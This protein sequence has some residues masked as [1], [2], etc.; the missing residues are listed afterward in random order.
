MQRMPAAVQEWVDREFWGIV[1]GL[2]DTFTAKMRPYSDDP[3]PHEEEL[4]P[5]ESEADGDDDGIEWP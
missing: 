1:A 5:W 4:E 2:G 3:Q